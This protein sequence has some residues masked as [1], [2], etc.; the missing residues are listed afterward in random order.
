M[1][2]NDIGKI[3]SRTTKKKLIEISTAKE[4]KLEKRINAIN[5]LAAKKEMD[6]TDV[7]GKVL[8]DKKEQAV[9]KSNLV[10]RLGH[11]LK[12]VR[13]L[14]NFLGKENV[15][16]DRSILQVLAYKGNKKSVEKINAFAKGKRRS[17]PELKKAQFAKTLISYR[18]GDNK[19]ILPKSKP[20]AFENFRGISAEFIK[21]EKL[22]KTKAAEIIAELDDAYMAVPLAAEKAQKLN[23]QGKNLSIFLNE[24]VAANNF[25]FNTNGIVASISE[26]DYCPG[27][28][29][30]KYHVLINKVG[31]TGKHRVHVINPNGQVLM[32]GPASKEGNRFS[33]KVK[34]LKRA[35][36]TPILF[37]ASFDL[38][39]TE[40]IIKEAKSG[41]GLRKSSII[42]LSSLN[43]D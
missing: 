31:K 2:S 13:T 9:V 41:T 38:S 4:E 34:A 17:T 3:S 19:E 33:F 35:G 15:M 20:E 11:R 30:I 12:S 18:F 10:L 22:S 37:D 24:K 6:P 1:Y 16:I 21:K 29:F 14:E 43:K 28:H 42:R 25:D 32:E 36:S 5:L 8:K 39:K 23:C 27:G 7:F 26:D 40:L